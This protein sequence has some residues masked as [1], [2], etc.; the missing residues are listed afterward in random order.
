[1]LH[2]LWSW[3][4]TLKDTD[5]LF[6]FLGFLGSGVFW[7]S[8]VLAVALPISKIKWKTPVSK[9]VLCSSGAP[10]GWLNNFFKKKKAS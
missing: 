4:E 6:C 2:V 5:V 7:W 10:I 9:N 3:V 8:L 1:V